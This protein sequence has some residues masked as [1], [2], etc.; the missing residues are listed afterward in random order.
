M[1]ATL[2]L[3]RGVPMLLGGDE[4]RRTQRGNNN[5]YCQDNELS[6]V[7]WS[8]QERQQSLIRFV[9]KLTW[10]RHQYPILCRSRFFTGEYNEELD[11]KDLTW[12][13]ATGVEMR[14]EDWSDANIRC[15]G[16]LMDGCA[17]PTGVRQ[18]GTE[19]T[20][21]LILNAHHDLVKFKL[22]AHPRGRTWS[23]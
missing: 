1:L 22:P 6:W 10:L 8:L 5:A 7:D 15:F 18:R 19:A 16:M 2:L 13:N 11:V 9:Q 17:Q 21:L 12:I 3:S 23:L 20:L 4:F 14:T